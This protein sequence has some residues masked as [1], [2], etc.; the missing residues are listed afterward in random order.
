MPYTL[1]Y[2]APSLKV[3]SAQSVADT[4]RATCATQPTGIQ[5]VYEVPT[6]AFDAGAPGAALLDEIAVGIEQLVSNN[7]VTGGS[8]LQDFDNNG[9]LQ[10]YV[11]LTVSYTPP[12]SGFPPLTAAAQILVD[13]FLSQQTGIGGLVIVP[14]GSVTPASACDAVY[15]NLQTLAAG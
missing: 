13:D 1:L 9:L 12:G 7:H 3:F 8:A 14:P 15:A 10:D 4:V 5:Y 2:S 6:A 11:S